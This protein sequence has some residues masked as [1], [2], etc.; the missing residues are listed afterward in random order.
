[1]TVDKKHD[2]VELAIGASSLLRN[3]ECINEP[4]S[5]HFLHPLQ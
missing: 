5:R 2:L 1:L 3:S 4:P